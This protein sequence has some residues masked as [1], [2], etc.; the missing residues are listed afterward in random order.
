[1]RRC[2]PPLRLLRFPVYA[3]VLVAMLAPHLP[4]E[5]LFTA[6]TLAEGTLYSDQVARRHGDLITVRIAETT[7]VNES[8]KTTRSRENTVD[9]GLSLLPGSNRLP[10]AAG[11]VASGRLPGVG[12]SSSK[13]YEGEGKLENTGTL[14]ATVTG[15][16][17]D[18]LDNGNLVI[19]VR[20][21]IRVKQDA[22][23][24]LLSGI[25][26]TADIS[27]GNVIMSEKLHNFQVALEGHGPLSR[28]E[29]EGWLSRLLDVLWPL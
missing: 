18:V 11:E 1:M 15:R 26:R 2:L 21:T 4:A 28:T 20:R 14:R 7:T 25:C 6:T 10:A 16:V 9:A 17:I 22:K 24:I 19:E 5:S 8:T 13:E 12:F 23:T 3:C 27:A 29:Q